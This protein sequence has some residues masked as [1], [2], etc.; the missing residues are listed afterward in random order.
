MHAWGGDPGVCSPAL[1]DLGQLS[2]GY[3]ARS[4]RHGHGGSP[5]QRHQERPENRAL[6]VA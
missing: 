6:S 5:D 4:R 1:L 2:C 3:Q